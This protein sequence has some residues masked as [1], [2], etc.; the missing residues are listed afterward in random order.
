[1]FP[2]MVLGGLSILLYSF[3]PLLL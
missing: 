2:V 1:M 3:P